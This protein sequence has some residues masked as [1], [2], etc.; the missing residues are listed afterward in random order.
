MPS[1]GF[2]RIG[3]RRG[4]MQAMSQ[5]LAEA[6]EAIELGTRR[7]RRARAVMAADQLDITHDRL[8]LTEE[9][10]GEEKS[11]PPARSKAPGGAGP[12]SRRRR[13]DIL[14]G[15]RGGGG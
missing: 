12:P 14:R 5:R 15:M 13:R 3:D 4:E 10:R 9:A 8:Q 7:W 2:Y 1:C 6:V 11:P